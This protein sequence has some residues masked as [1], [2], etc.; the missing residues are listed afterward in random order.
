MCARAQAKVQ[1]ARTKQLDATGLL[2]KLLEA[3]DA[4]SLAAAEVENINEN[5]FLMA[6]TYLQMVSQ[7]QE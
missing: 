7:P 6:S 5:F 1:R 2:A 3:K 4:R